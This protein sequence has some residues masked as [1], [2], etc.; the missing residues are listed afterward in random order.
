[1]IANEYVYGGLLCGMAQLRTLVPQL[2]EISGYTRIVVDEIDECS[3][4]DQKAIVKE[5]QALCTTP[6][7]RCKALF[8]SRKDVHI[9]KKLAKQPQISLDNRQEVDCDIRAFF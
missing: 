4:K 6:I 8:S 9:R 3:K 1:M 2:R 7:L 5:L